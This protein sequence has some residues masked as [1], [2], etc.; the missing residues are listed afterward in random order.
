MAAHLKQE[1]EIEKSDGDSSPRERWRAD[2]QYSMP[3]DGKVRRKVDLHVLP[4][5]AVLYLCSFL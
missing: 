3:V 1:P 5:I 2:N 4:L